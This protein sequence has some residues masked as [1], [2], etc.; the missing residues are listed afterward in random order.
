M[1]ISILGKGPFIIVGVF[2]GTT[3]NSCG[4]YYFFIFQKIS[5]ALIL[6]ISTFLLVQSMISYTNKFPSHLTIIF[7]FLLPTH[8]PICYHFL[9]PLLQLSILTV[10]LFSLT[11]PFYGTPFL[12]LQFTLH[13][14]VFSLCNITVLSFCM[15]LICCNCKL[16]LMCM[17]VCMY[18]V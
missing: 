9:F 14:V 15:C 16:D 2:C 18:F 4:G 6:S 1:C 13:F 5:L 10:I 7:S 17:C 8:D 3:I 11:H 12:N